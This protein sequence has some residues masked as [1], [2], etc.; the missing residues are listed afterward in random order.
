MLIALDHHLL[1]ITCII[2]YVAELSVVTGVSDRRCPIPI[3]IVYRY[4]PLQQFVNWYR[5]RP[6]FLA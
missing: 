1:L 2:T 4:S 6:P 5:F 3:K